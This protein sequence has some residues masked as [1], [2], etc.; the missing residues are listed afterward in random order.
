MGRFEQFAAVPVLKS[1]LN[2]LVAFKFFREVRFK[3]F[4][5][6]QQKT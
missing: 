2:Q 3:K 4:R 6:F 5:L 1:F